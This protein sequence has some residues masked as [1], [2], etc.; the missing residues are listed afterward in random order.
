MTTTLRPTGPERYDADGVRSRCYDICVNSRPVGSLELTADSRKGPATGRV[1]RLAVD[2][3]ERRRGRGAV[4]VLAAEEVLRRWGCDR[5]E[6]SIPA[7]A[8]A[9][10]K[11]AGSLGYRERGRS[12]VKELGARPQLP[13]GS[14]ARPMT[15]AE[16]PAWRE[17]GQRKLQPLLAERG[18]PADE[19]ERRAADS[20]DALLPQGAGTPGAALRVLV[21]GGED[22]GVVWVEL[23]RSPREDADSYVY[24]VEV[25]EALRGRGHGRTL[26]LVAEREAIDAGAGV[27]GLHVFAY[28]STA[29][30]LYSSLGYRVVEHHFFKPLL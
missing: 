30:S 26:M 28:N 5:V 20:F 12:M 27:L 13:P 15:D 25:D 19:V 2:E 17:R 14:T 8:E 11:L 21:H 3:E 6:T 1:A 9:A 16:F 22:V 24:E 18:V 23:E 10:L 4:A 29:L 7:G